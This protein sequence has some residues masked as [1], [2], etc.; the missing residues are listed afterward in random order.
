M[1]PSIAEQHCQQI[2]QAVKE[3]PESCEIFQKAMDAINKPYIVINGPDGGSQELAIN[4]IT[5]IQRIHL[6]RCPIYSTPE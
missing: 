5:T 4:T 2:I 3:N 6:P 1:S